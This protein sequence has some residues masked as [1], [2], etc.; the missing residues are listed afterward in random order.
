[1]PHLMLHIALI[2]GAEYRAI[3]VEHFNA[4]AFTESQEWGL[5]GPSSRASM[6][7]RSA[8]HAEQEP[9][10]LRGVA[11]QGQSFLAI[12]AMRPFNSRA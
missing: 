11:P 6:A 9:R 12:A 2:N 8:M 1:M 5:G 4:H 10:I 7:R 3:G